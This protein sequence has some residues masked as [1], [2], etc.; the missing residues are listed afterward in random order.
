M[1]VIPDGL[2]STLPGL[3]G[4]HQPLVL[5][6]SH[7][8]CI[9]QC[10]CISLMRPIKTTY[11]QVPVVFLL[12]GLHCTYLQILYYINLETQDFTEVVTFSCFCCCNIDKLYN[13]L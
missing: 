9:F 10:K 4:I 5:Y 1:S 13:L 3:G 2:E 11:Q 12:S 8:F 7:E 6:F